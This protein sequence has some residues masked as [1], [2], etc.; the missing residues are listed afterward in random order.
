LEPKLDSAFSNVT[1][2]IG[3]TALLLCSIENLGKYK[4]A[5]LDSN[6]ITLTYEERRIVD[7]SRFAI[8][9]PNV[10]NWHLQVRE[11]RMSDAGQ[12]RCTVN[13]YL[14]KRKVVHLFVNVPP[15]ILGPSPSKE[16]IVVHEGANL[17]IA[18][19]ATGSPQPEI[20]WSR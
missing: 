14:V 4:V 18:C 11:V 13:T 19:N 20:T 15:T 2:I 5:W 8:E 6:S 16:I 7:D 9:R 3:Q 12:Y 10:E 17:T 1:V